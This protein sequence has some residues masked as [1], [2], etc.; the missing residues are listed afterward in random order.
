MVWYQTENIRNIAILGHAGSGKT[1]L[2]EALLAASGEITHQ[3]SIEKG[4]TVCDFDKNEIQ[5]QHSTDCSVCS[6]D[7]AGAHVNL[8]DSPGYPDFY[9]RSIAVL[10]AVETAA[11]VMNA[12]TGVELISRRIMDAAA[13]R[14]LCRLIIINKIDIA[15]T[16]LST[17]FEQV[18]SAFGK[19]CLPLNLPAEQ[20]RKVV[21]CYFSPS[22]QVTDFSSVT[23]AHDALID[24]V[25]EVDDELMETYLEQEQSL[26]PKQLHKAFEQ[27]LREGRLV[28]I[29]FVS[30]RTGAGIDLL[31]K[32][33]EEL[34]P[35]PFEGNPPIFLKGLEDKAVHISQKK[36][37]HVLAHVFKVIINP[38]YGRLGLFRIHQGTIQNNT[39]LYIGEGRK[40]FKVG[41]LLK[42]QGKHPKELSEGISGDIG[43][44]AK[45]DEVYYDAV[46]HDHHDEDLF[47]L[48]QMNFLPPMHGLA[49]STTRQGDEQKLSEA[50]AK[51]IAE[52]PGLHIEH[53]ANVDETILRGSSELH[54]RTV[55]DKMKS[56]Y[57]LDVKTSLPSIAYAETITQS[58]EGHH[59]HKKQSGGAGQFGEVLLRVEP[60]QRGSGIEFVNK[61]VGG[62]IP[63]QFIPA[64][65]K[66]VHHA[67]DSGVYAG[68]PLQDIRVTVHGG[69]FHA[70]DSKEIAFV[71][72]G[73]KA[74]INA[75]EKAHPIVLE[76]VVNIQINI[77]DI[78]TGVINANISTMRG[79]ITGSSTLNNNRVEV[80][81]Q[82]P[83]SEMND[84]QTRLNSETGGEGT[85]CMEF[86]HYQPAPDKMQRSLH[87][88]FKKETQ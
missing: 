35:N 21:D 70:V 25:V 36:D 61:I 10:P 83:L 18:Q 86:S 17:L 45:V 5:L 33:F 26:S 7:H 53:R 39:H 50:L 80:D 56:Q 4:N 37:D 78:N 68:Y 22:D 47:H 16:N 64:L 77:P 71:M 28:P 23:E 65:E 19:A 66:G 9:N 14:N 32:I 41:H 30:T 74:F 67:I 29:C 76:P 8:I 57:Q 44:V 40:A 46:L 88:A 51:L 84:Y 79:L 63:S 58:A 48:K 2:T 24:Q 72:A 6:F 27:V 69:K 87:Q 85:Y 43:A 75:I 12:Q 31:L 55:M 11:V 62:V 54:L 81:C 82:V 38:Y 13:K 52:D 20:G 15:D 49:I 42:L 73:K 60:L 3:G 59:R 1:T 34:M